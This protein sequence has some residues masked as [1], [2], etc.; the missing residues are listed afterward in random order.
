MPGK[1]CAN[2]KNF[3]KNFEWRLEYFLYCRKCN[4]HVHSEL[5]E[6]VEDV[7]SSKELELL[8]SIGLY[9]DYS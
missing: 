3:A 9:F 2:Q 7:F 1:N 4:R 5:R 8:H 6:A